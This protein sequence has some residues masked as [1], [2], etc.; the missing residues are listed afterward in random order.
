MILRN[1][2]FVGANLR[3][4]AYSPAVLA[5]LNGCL[6]DN[7]SLALQALQTLVHLAPHLDVSGQKL[8]SDKL[9][10]AGDGGG[11]ALCPMRNNLV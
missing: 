7:G 9:F 6:Y 1:L 4:L 3:L 5:L 2:S 8:L 11:P 10:Y